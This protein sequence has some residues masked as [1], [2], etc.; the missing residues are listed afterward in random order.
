MALTWLEAGP[1]ALV[2]SKALV[3]ISSRIVWNDPVCVGL[4]SVP[5]LFSTCGLY[6]S[7]MT[8]MPTKLFTVSSNISDFTT[9]PVRPYQHLSCSPSAK[10]SL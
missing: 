7:M 6:A 1:S 9:I 10:L 8:G 3:A 5:K 4:W 2:S